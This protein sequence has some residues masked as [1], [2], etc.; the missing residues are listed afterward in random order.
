LFSQWALRKRHF[1]KFEGQ[2]GAKSIPRGG[3]TPSPQELEVFKGIKTC[4]VT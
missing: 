2:K 3:E 4:G 1:P